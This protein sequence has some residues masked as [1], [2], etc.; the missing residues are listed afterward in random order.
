MEFNLGYRFERL[1]RGVESGIV[2]KVESFEVPLNGSRDDYEDDNG[3]LPQDIAFKN[4]LGELFVGAPLMVRKDVKTKSGD[5]YQLV[6]KE[7]NI[8]DLYP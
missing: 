2:E 3:N 7:Y 6:Y 8:G 4:P 1:I 5:F